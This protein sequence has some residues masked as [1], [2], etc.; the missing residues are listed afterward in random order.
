MPIDYFAYGA[1]MSPDHMRRVVRGWGS[2]SRGVLRGYRLVF[3]SYSQAWRGGV[4]GLREDPGGEVYG[5]VYTLDEEQ[6]GI[7]DRYEGVPY[8]RVRIK[9]SVAMEHG[10]TSAFTHI[11]ANPRSH[12]APSRSYLSALIK[13]LRQAGYGEDIVRQAERAAMG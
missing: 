6:L 10:L 11:S 5:V 7:L 2:L 9:V 1:L 8:S 12:V 3:D 13:G 4:A